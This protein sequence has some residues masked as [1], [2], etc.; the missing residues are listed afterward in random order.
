MTFQIVLEIPHY[1]DRD[2]ICAW[3]IERLPNAYETEALAHKIA[4]RWNYC[5]PMAAHVV[6]F[7]GDW[8]KERLWPRF[9]RITN[10]DDFPF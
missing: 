2:A 7:D 10:A 3:S 8:R 6:P 4:E 1:D 5:D 9:M